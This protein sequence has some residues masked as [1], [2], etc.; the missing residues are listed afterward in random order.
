MAVL[1]EERVKRMPIAEADVLEDLRRGFI[2]WHG[3][4]RKC[5]PCLVIRIERLKA[6]KSNKE[7]SIRLVLFALEYAIRFAMVPGR[8]E[9][10]VVLIDLDNAMSVVS[11]SSMMSLAGTMKAIALTLESVYCGRM[12]WLKMFNMSSSMRSIVEGVIPKEK[13][14]KVSTVPPGE[15]EQVMRQFFEPHQIEARYGGTAPNLSP[16]SVYPFHFFPNCTGAS[17]KGVEAQDSSLHPH[18]SRAF[19][20]GLFWDSSTEAAKSRWWTAAPRQGLAPAAARALGVPNA[21]N[22]RRSWTS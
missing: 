12:V 3:R 2:Y 16:E 4:D 1:L 6:L 21:A 17:G 5:R 22:A 11:W 18:S 20:E 9:N 15:H 7:A 19:H 10:W 8:V 14:K 13:K